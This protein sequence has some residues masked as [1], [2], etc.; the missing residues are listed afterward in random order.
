MTTPP[1]KQTQFSNPD[2]SDVGS[3][4]SASD[5]HSVTKIDADQKRGIDSALIERVSQILENSDIKA[6]R[7]RVDVAAV[8]LDRNIHL[9]ADEVF[10]K[11]EAMGS[12]VSRATVYNTLSLMVERGILAQVIVDPTRVFYDSN[13]TAHHHVFDTDSGRL[14][15]VMPGEVSI[16]RLPTLPAGKR[17]EGVDVIIR[18][19]SG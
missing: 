17:L 11:V 16:G 15:D 2:Q 7:Q 18:V 10:T 19:T 4:G 6:T 12:T 1:S 8:L 5:A 14:T 9:S 3:E 13:T